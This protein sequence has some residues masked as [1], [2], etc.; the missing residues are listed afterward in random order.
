MKSALLSIIIFSFSITAHG[1]VSNG[2]NIPIEL[3]SISM[4]EVHSMKLGVI[5]EGDFV[6]EDETD[7]HTKEWF[8]TIPSGYKLSL[9]ADDNVVTSL[10]VMH[11]FFE[12][13]R[14]IKVGDKLSTVRGVYPDSI[15]SCDVSMFR[16]SGSLFL[17]SKNQKI[18]FIFYDKKISSKIRQGVK[19][20]IDD[21]EIQ[22]L[23]LYRISIGEAPKGLE[24]SDN[25]ITGE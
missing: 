2:S 24:S 13:D 21:P 23:E 16:N 6:D 8:L 7:V 10:K 5:E 12:T 22:A 19:C 14:G 11:P 1:D 3:I 25:G 9:F 15:F 4:D 20:S 17:Y 18:I